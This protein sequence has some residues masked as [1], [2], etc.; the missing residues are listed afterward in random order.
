MKCHLCGYKSAREFVGSA[1]HLDDRVRDVNSNWDP[2]THGKVSLTLLASLRQR[3][4]VPGGTAPTWLE[5]PYWCPPKLP[6]HPGPWPKNR[7]AYVSITDTWRP[8]RATVLLST[9]HSSFRPPLKLPSTNPSNFHK[10]LVS[11]L[12]S[13]VKFLALSLIWKRNLISSATSRPWKSGICNS[14][15][16]LKDSSKWFFQDSFWSFRSSTDRRL[17]VR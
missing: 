12:S 8:L 5:E 13:L 3:W 10:T 9:R 4:W 11:L 6:I 14:S 7:G 15:V 17:F 1:F 2:V 16:Y